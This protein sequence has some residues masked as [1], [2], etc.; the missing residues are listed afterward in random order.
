MLIETVTRQWKSTISDVLKMTFAGDGTSISLLGS[1]MSDGNLVMDPHTEDEFD[2]EN[3]AERV[4][5]SILIPHTWAMNGDYPF[6]ATTGDGCDAVGP[7]DYKYILPED[8]EK[9]K[10]CANG[11]LYYLL[12]AKGDGQNCIQYYNNN[13]DCNQNYFQSLPGIDDL[14]SGLFNV[15]VDDIVVG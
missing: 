3:A 12:D 9:A 8:G 7:L 15:S 11:Q 6:I 1:L 5:W 13:E 2:Y 10:V 14:S 4:I